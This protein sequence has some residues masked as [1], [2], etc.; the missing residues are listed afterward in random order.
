[1]TTKSEFISDSSTLFIYTAKKRLARYIGIFA[2][3]NAFPSNINNFAWIKL[4]STYK[5]EGKTYKREAEDFNPFEQSI[6]PT[7]W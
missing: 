2:G 5:I 6:H 7:L 1:L 3:P 4:S